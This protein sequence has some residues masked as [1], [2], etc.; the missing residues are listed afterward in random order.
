VSARS[1]G[2]V[3][4]VPEPKTRATSDSVEEFLAAVADE[5]RRRD[6]LAVCALMAEVTGEPPRMW[7]PSMVGFGQHHYRYASGHE[8]DT[9]LVGFAPRRTALTV[10]L[11][12]GFDGRE[13]LLARLG[14]HSTGKACL[15]IKRL[16]DVDVDVLRELVAASVANRGQE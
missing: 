2:T 14:K 12:D 16:D 15:Y 11:M 4:L 9:F 6:A 5:R 8:G 13:E 10:Y 3:A 1:A 7:G